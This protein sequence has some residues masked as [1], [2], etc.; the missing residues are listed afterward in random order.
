MIHVCIE[1][2]L[3][4]AYIVTAAFSGEAMH[5]SN[6]YNYR[7]TISWVHLQVSSLW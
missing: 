2:I 4:Y 1:L 3:H 6:Y 5:V 7:V